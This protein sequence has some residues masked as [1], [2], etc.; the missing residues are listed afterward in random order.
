[1]T[2]SRAEK[3]YLTALRACLEYGDR[4]EG[5]NGGTRSLF[6][7]MLEFNLQEGFPLMTSKS[8]HFK[9]V[10]EELLWFLSGK[11]DNVKPLQEAG[12]SI[13][14]E[15]ADKTGNLGPIYGCQWRD[16]KSECYGWTD[17]IADLVSELKHHPNS[18]R[19]I[20]SAWNVGEIHYMALPPCHV[21]FQCYVQDGYLDMVMTQRS[22]DVFLGLPFNI[23]SYAL[24]NSMLSHVTGL[25]PRWLKICIGDMH[26]YENHVDQARTQMLRACHP[27]PELFLAEDVTDIDDFKSEHIRLL[28]YKHSGK[29]PAPVSK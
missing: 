10:R 23:A 29:L 12:V 4:R 17:Q 8:V 22:A 14:D 27:L 24:L 15:W 20:V 13:W 19:H 28:G 26:L 21:M 3:T 5:R 11:C 7:N 25:Q 6:G 1:M 18:R 2:Q 9:S 16:W